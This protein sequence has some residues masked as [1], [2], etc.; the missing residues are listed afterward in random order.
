M[1]T[2]AV[3]LLPWLLAPAAFAHAAGSELACQQLTCSTLIPAPPVDDGATNDCGYRTR[4]QWWLDYVAGSLAWRGDGEKTPITVAVFDDGAHITHPELRNRL[5][6]NTAESQGTPG[7][8][9][10]GNGFV[11]DVHGWDFVDDDPRV[12]PEG[13]CS[14]RPSHGTFMASLIAGERNNGTGIA[15]AGSEGAR[16]MILRITGCGGEKARMQPDRLVRA[17]DY[18]RRMGAR[19]MSFSAHWS[20]TSAELDAAFEEIAS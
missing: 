6:I 9:D 7:K 19:I 20:V 11:D 10:D 2:F 17:L 1:A 4:N 12:A 5:W 16:V 3:R 8:D 18:A 13:E 14:N 15:A